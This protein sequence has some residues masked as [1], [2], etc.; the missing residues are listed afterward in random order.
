MIEL[1]IAVGVALGI[2]LAGLVPIL[3]YAVVVGALELYEYLRPERTLLYEIDP[4]NDSTTVYEIDAENGEIGRVM[5]VF[6]VDRDTA[7]KM[8]SESVDIDRS[9]D[10]ESRQAGDQR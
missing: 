2:L 3:L 9:D 7:E 10:N 8:L 6:G 1:T 5:D 4:V